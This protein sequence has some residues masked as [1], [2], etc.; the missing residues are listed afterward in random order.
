MISIILGAPCKSENTQA[1][2]IK[3][4]KHFYWTCKFFSYK[5][6]RSI[7]SIPPYIF[8]ILNLTTESLKKKEKGNRFPTTFLWKVFAVFC[9]NKIKIKLKFSELK[10]WY[11]SSI[12]ILL[13]NKLVLCISKFNLQN[14]HDSRRKFHIEFW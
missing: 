2:A 13:R 4:I 5:I 12:Y 3:Q 14:M 9:K 6:N 10:A 1:L 8:L 7:F 11:K